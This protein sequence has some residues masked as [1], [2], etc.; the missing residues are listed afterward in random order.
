MVK[1][2][3]ALD[4]YTELKTTTPQLY[5]LST[6][7]H[8]LSGDVIHLKAYLKELENFVKMFSRASKIS[9][10]HVKEL[11]NLFGRIKATFMGLSAV[12]QELEVYKPEIEK[13]L[14]FKFVH[15]SQLMN[16]LSSTIDNQLFNLLPTLSQ[17]S[18]REQFKKSLEQFLNTFRFLNTYVYLFHVR[19]SSLLVQEHE[20]FKNTLSYHLDSFFA[21]YRIFEF[22][23]PRVCNF[24]EI[25]QGLLWDLHYL[26]TLL[27]SSPLY[28]HSSLKYKL[29]L[30]YQQ[31]YTLFNS[32]TSNLS[33]D[34]VVY[35]IAVVTQMKEKD[36]LLE[37]FSSLKKIVLKS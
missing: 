23:D 4:I 11:Y 21:H 8:V 6:S 35:R 14:S 2:A 28:F 16:V 32:L 1:G 26:E 37:F 27:N 3:E 22:T 10:D 12:L 29:N 13:T 19:I 34:F 15:L 5:S 9:S 17:V 25:V 33:D 18:C 7:S 31:L 24:K 20:K 36:G 30:V